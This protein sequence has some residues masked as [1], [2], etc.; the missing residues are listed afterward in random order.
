VK[1]SPEKGW[2]S[3]GNLDPQRA[4]ALDRALIMSRLLD[5]RYFP[6]VSEAIKKGKEGETLFKEACN[7]AK[8]PPEMIGAIWKILLFIEKDRTIAAPVDW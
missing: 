5:R 4:Q 6:R 2:E 7:E 1:K 3:S 8:I